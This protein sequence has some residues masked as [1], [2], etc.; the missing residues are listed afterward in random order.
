MT[1]PYFLRSLLLLALALGSLAAP[2][3]I[4]DI[5]PVFPT[6]ND[7][8]T[9]IYDAT[10]GNGELV[11]VTPV[12]AHTGVITNQSTSPSDW[13]YVQ[14]N[15]GTADPKVLMEDLGNN[16]HRIRYHIR[17]YYNLPVGEQVKELA[18]VFRNQAGTLVGRDPNG[19]DIY[20]PVYDGSGLVA[21]FLT[22]TANLVTTANTQQIFR[23]A[24]SQTSTLT[25]FVNNNPVQTRSG[26][27]LRDTLTLATPGEYVIRFQADNGSEVVEDTIVWVVRGP[28]SIQNPPTGIEPGITYLSDTSALLALYAPRKDFVYVIGDFNDWT[29]RDEGYMRLSA[30]STLWWLQVNGLTPGEE[31]AFQY[32]VD[33]TLRIADPYSE[34]VLD[35]WND[36]FISSA[37]YPDLKPYPTGRTT[38]PV[39]VL[40]TGQQPYAW[41]HS[42]YQR[43]ANEDLIVYELLLRDFLAAHDYQTLIDTL[44]YLQRLGINAIELMPVMEF[45]GNISWGYNPSFFFA[46]D[47]Y[48]G[49]ADDLRAFIDACHGRGIAVIL[50]MVLN[51]AF[52]QNPLVRL[53]WDGANSRPADDSP[54]FNPIARHPFNVGYDFNHESEQTKYF[55]DRVL[56]YWVEEFQFD[57][58]RMDLSKGFTQVNSGSDVGLWGQY[59]A[60]RIALIKRM[61]DA[62]RG[63]DPEV[64]FIL[65]HFG[66]NQEE[67]EL[68]E[69]GMMLWGN[70]NHA[71]NEATM[72]YH[73]SNKSNFNWISYKQRNWNVPHVVGYMESHDEERLMLK[74]RRFGNST[75][76]Y[77]VRQL[78]TG[79]ARVEMAAAFFIPIPGP[80]MIWQFGELGY[81][82][83]INYCPNGTENNNCRVDV[84]PIRWNYW[85]NQYNRQRLYGVFAALNHLKV[86]EPVFRTED[87]ELSVASAF[88]RIVLRDTSMNVVVIGNFDVVPRSGSG[89]FPHTGRWYDYFLG[90]SI[91]VT[92]VAASFELAAGEWHFYTDKRLAEPAVS[93]S[94]ETLA[95][96]Q[97]FGAYPNPSD[98]T[99][100][101]EWMQASAQPVRLSIHDLAGRELAVVA[102]E[103]ALPGLQSFT[104]DGRT[105][106]GQ[107]VAAGVYLARLQAGGRV[108]TLR[109]LRD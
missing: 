45:E 108:F 6:T 4:L 33:G 73:D 1:Q 51:H 36:P 47:K 81:D 76:N 54:W 74:N 7:T 42:G 24:S 94:V 26:K 11:G 13:R 79:L 32:L 3:Q 77:D 5:D 43:P 90:D 2:A 38:E 62:L 80:K 59:D 56:A 64:Y 98:E 96:V 12:Y 44:D 93:V 37:T 55:V 109:L 104:W 22:P 69:Y 10:Q 35:P 99:V 41:Q 95:E 30:D 19:S 72:G 14:G 28:V 107:P 101:L 92:D 86:S 89:N 82:Y 85:N 39:S 105:A 52:G 50:D 66:G 46:P 31:Y 102:D 67:K 97:A 29:P 70:L 75:W 63:V 91:E 25:L 57:G 8:V 60:S 58:Y 49:P 9:I 65:E 40:Q 71:Y 23:A 83:S 27:E 106:A 48:Y 15:W 34:K 17:S 18:F 88:K 61:Y 21:A 53:Y 78:N 20:Y 84:K 68:A 103:A 87:F 100:S 16:K